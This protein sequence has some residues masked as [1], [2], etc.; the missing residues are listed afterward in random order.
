M[1]QECVKI[2]VGGIILTAKG[3]RRFQVQGEPWLDATESFYLAEVEMIDRDSSRE[4][5]LNC[6]DSKEAEKLS[7]EIPSLVTRCV[8]W[9]VDTAFML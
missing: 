4:E 2:D 6:Q 3:D 7:R 1:N 9:V 5:L 8:D